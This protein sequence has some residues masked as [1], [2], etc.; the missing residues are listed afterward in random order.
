MAEMESVLNDLTWEQ[1]HSVTIPDAD[2]TDD[3]FELDLNDQSCNGSI[4]TG[5]YPFEVGET[6]YPYARYDEQEDLERGKGEIHIEDFI[7][8]GNDENANN[9]PTGQCYD[10]MDCPTMTAA[11]RISLAP[12]G[13]FYDGRR[14]FYCDGPCGENASWQPQLTI[15]EGPLVTKATS[16]NPNQVTIA[17]ETD[18]ASWC[19]VYVP[20]V[21]SFMAG[22]KMLPMSKFSTQDSND[23]PY[24]VL[25]SGSEKAKRHEIL[26]TGLTPDTTYQYQVHCVTEDE[27]VRSNTCSFHTAPEAGATTQVTFGFGSDSR[28][29]QAGGE[30]Q[31]MG[32]NFKTLSRIANDAYRRGA[33]LFIFGGDLV[34]G[35][36]SS[37]DDFILQL[38]GWKKSMEGF[39]RFHPVFPAMGN[40]E[41]LLKIFDDGSHYG[42]SLDRWPY[43]TDSAEAVFAQEFFNPENGPEPADER[44]PT[45]KEN[46]FTFQYGQVLFMAFNN[47]YWWTTNDA[48]SEYGGCPEGYMMD[49]QLTWVENV[50]ADAEN[51]ETI[52]YIFL[53][54]QEP[55][56]PNGGHPEDA[57]WWNGNNNI[58]GFFKNEAG[59]VIPAGEGIVQVRNRFWEAIAQSSKVAAV[60][61]G[62][63]HLYHRTLIDSN[64]RVGVYPQDDLNGDGIL[65]V[66]SANPNFT[67][68]TWHI[69]AGNA[70]APWYAEEDLPWQPEVAQSR[71]GYVL[72]TVDPVQDTVELKAIANRGDE[73]ID[74]V[75][76]LMGVK[77]LTSLSN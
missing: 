66:Y 1:I 45:Y 25:K 43:A 6:M 69:T 5:P 39:W 7:E 61:T 60:L 71:I 56:F 46:L 31:F 67:N 18:Q 51:D 2:P 15:V 53:Y 68:P 9:W 52:N 38:K 8:T 73:I 13:D 33:D 32:H 35:Y 16:D 27:V 48:V 20:T 3:G 17:A 75:P 34:N 44:R 24:T 36:T 72:I 4:Y 41:T 76:N 10:P 23:Y 54:A 74:E 14:S 57:M 65:D 19:M 64:T 77:G 55:V 40:H 37:K 42:I 49:D 12:D 63:E 47:N 58:K 26:L 21:G 28:E 70:G 30:E 11:Y 50:L 62:D 29:G 59:E 22:S